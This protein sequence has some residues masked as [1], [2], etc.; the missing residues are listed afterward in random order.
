MNLLIVDDEKLTR[1]GLLNTIVW[2]ELNIENV[3]L[4]CDGIQGLEI[5]KKEHP[6]IVLTDVR[7]PRMDGIQ[8]AEKIQQLSP[9]TVVIFMSGYSDK[10]YLK[11]A[12][13]LKAVDYVEKPISTEEVSNAVRKAIETVELLC[14]TRQSE[15]YAKQEKRGQLSLELIQNGK[16]RNH[17]YRMIEELELP[18]S[19]HSDFVT[20]IVHFFKPLIET[21]ALSYPIMMQSFKQ[22]AAS[23]NVNI[24][25]ARKYDNYLIIHFY[26]RDIT[27]NNRVE[28]CIK[29]LKKRLEEEYDF[30]IAV[31]TK[32][33][34]IEKIHQSYN[35]AAFLLQS[36]FFH[37]INSILTNSP[38][39]KKA[40]LAD[41]VT[42]QMN[43][44]FMMKDRA[45]VEK[46]CQ[47][48]YSELECCHNLLASQAKDVYYKYFVILENAFIKN[49]LLQH[50]NF[51]ENT[52]IW[53]KISHCRTLSD[54]HTMFLKQIELFFSM[55]EDTR[56]E[57]STIFEIKK[58]IQKNISNET[59]SIKDISS[60][61]HLS[62][63]YICTFF[64]NE[65]GITLNQYITEC[66]LNIA[67]Q[68]LEK[69]N[70]TVNEIA[71]K[72][73]YRDGNYFGKAFKKITGLS[74][75]EYR[76]KII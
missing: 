5:V 58:F 10:E 8:M 76:E 52:S 47:S 27:Y 29:E 73:G 42:V 33:N 35:D 51:V 3:F 28:R 37:E 38:V 25:Y 12:I 49:Q 44:A 36:E 16:D 15:S 63:S 22:F 23:Y 66:R 20:C 19:E 7:M 45:A 21:G 61:V 60:Y 30:F 75:T 64:K 14:R 34:G 55:T 74:P 43:E 9:E 72:V 40:V 1:E 26:G 41:N 24:L 69:T 11:S 68:M 17:L 48:I 2:D 70:Y 50:E 57:N 6:Q 4:A 71:S 13:R 39:N 31:G 67:K 65:T 53:E 18:V 46:L 56:E 59:I 32:V 54:L 62:S